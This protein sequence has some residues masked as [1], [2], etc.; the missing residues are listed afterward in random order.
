MEVDFLPSLGPVLFVVLDPPVPKEQSLIASGARKE[1]AL[2][3]E[4]SDLH[5]SA[6]KRFWSSPSVHLN[7]RL[8]DSRVD[9]RV[10]VIFHPVVPSLVP[11]VREVLRALILQP[12]W[13]PVLLVVTL[14]I[15]HLWFDLLRVKIVAGVIS[16]WEHDGRCVR[17]WISRNHLLLKAL[18]RAPV[19]RQPIDTIGQR[20]MEKV[21]RRLAI[22]IQPSHVRHGKQVFRAAVANEEL[23]RERW[24]NALRQLG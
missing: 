11:V 15:D 17:V 18:P 8:L 5:P 1:L 6:A 12:K 9:G 2:Q 23:D 4:V 16:C 22:L 21:P 19:V 24:N 20:P 3:H 13:C 14:G 10:P 7:K